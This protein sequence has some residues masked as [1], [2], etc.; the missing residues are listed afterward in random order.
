[1]PQKE[2][3]ENQPQEND[4]LDRLK[5]EI[6]D[7]KPNVLVREEYEDHTVG[8]GVIVAVPVGVSVF[9]Q[10]PQTLKLECV[11]FEPFDPARA[12]DSE[13]RL[14][15]ANHMRYVTLEELPKSGSSSV[16]SRLPRKGRPSF[17]ESNPNVAYS[18][19]E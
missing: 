4:S 11:D 6:E 19:F 2:K 16:M 15:V 14:A 10:H 18:H 12:H 7:R 17:V 3:N 9:I 5:A 13:Y 1:M 8:D